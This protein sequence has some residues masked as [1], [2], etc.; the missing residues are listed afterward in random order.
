MRICCEL[1]VEDLIDVIYIIFL[2]GNLWRLE[3][4]I[5]MF[6]IDIVSC[7]ERDKSRLKLDFSEN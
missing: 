5:V 6:V 1:E 4:L 3:K 7:N 2:Y